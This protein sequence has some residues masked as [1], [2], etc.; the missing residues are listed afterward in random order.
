MLYK[1]SVLLAKHNRSMIHS[2]SRLANQE[3]Y[4]SMKKR[5]T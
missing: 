3:K 5:V 1:S 2:I 4:D